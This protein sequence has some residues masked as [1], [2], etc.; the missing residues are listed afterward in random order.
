MNAES[1]MRFLFLILIGFSLYGCKE[2]SL[3]SSSPQ[4]LHSKYGRKK[5]FLWNKKITSNFDRIQR[6]CWYY[7]EASPSLGMS[8]KQ[9]ILSAVKLNEF[10]I[11]DEHV[12]KQLENIVKEKLINM[13]AEFV[14]CGLATISVGAAIASGGA[15]AIAFGV[16]S[17]WMANNCVKNSLNI[18]R[19]FNEFKG[20]S[21]GLASLEKG[22]TRLGRVFAASKQETDMFREAI[23]RARQLGLEDK[24]SCPKANHFAA[25]IK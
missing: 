16:S 6:S 7:K 9:A 21:D 2:K 12:E 8:D 1:V 23:R 3:E 15:S 10:A 17:A 20:T 22:E 11:H 14:P 5:I 4:T 24:V 25:D 13:G 18:G 19:Y